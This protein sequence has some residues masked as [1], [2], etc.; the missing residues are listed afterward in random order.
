[1]AKQSVA[2]SP[3]TREERGL[4]LARSRPEEIW[5]VDRHVWRVPSGSGETVYLVDLKLE[6]CSCEDFRRRQEPCKHLF[7]ARVIRAKSG[8]CAGCGRWFLGRDLIEVTEDH[9]SPTF[10]ASDIVCSECA[11]AHG[12]L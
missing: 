7:A 3:R 8:A 10:F 12:I 5:R 2:R 4:D 6:S 11:G 9:D 1:M